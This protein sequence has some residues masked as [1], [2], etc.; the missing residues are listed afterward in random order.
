MTVPALSSMYADKFKGKSRV[1]ML[2]PN[3]GSTENANEE[4]FSYAGISG[5]R[6][7]SDIFLQARK[8]HDTATLC[9]RNNCNQKIIT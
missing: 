4:E 5:S 3:L 2:K 6:S 7:L 8:S 1:S 9:T